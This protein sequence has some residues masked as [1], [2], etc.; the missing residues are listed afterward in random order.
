VAFSPDGKPLATASD[1]DVVQLWDPATGHATIPL[2]GHKD[3]VESVV[4]NPDG[5]TLASC[6]EDL[7]ARLWDVA[8]ARTTA[9]LS[10]HAG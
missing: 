7:T 8:A 9:V 1:T 10:A 6:S 4:F 5:K 2:I 3:A